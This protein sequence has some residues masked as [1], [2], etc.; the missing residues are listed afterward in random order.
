VHF[1]VDAGRKH[2]LLNGIDDIGETLEKAP[3]I[4]GFE[5]KMA[6]SRPWI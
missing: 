3:A 5:K 2:R 1:Q 4:D 6:Q